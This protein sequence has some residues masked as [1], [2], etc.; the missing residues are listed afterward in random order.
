MA[1]TYDEAVAAAK[2]HLE[3]EPF[4]DPVYRWCS[5]TGRAVAEGWYFDYSFERV[6]GKPCGTDEGFAGAPG[7]VVSSRDGTLRVMGWKEWQDR[8]LEA[9]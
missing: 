4:P 9:G 3:A 8:Q 7:Y 2:A 6:D 1:L 5:P